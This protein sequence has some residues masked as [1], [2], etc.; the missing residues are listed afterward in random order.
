[1]NRTFILLLLLLGVI[2]LGAQTIKG[3]ITNE[4]LEPVPFANVLVQEL[5]T[6]TTSD[7]QGYYELNL[8]TEGNY[9]LIFSSLGYTSHK[10][11]VI[12][13]LEPYE[14]NISLTTSDVLLNEITVAA[15]RKDPAYAIIKKVVER[16]DRH[17]RAADSYRTDIYVK[18]VEE[19]ERNERN[20]KP[21]ITLD[22]SPEEENGM[23][24][25]FAEEEKARKELLGRLNL[26]EME[27]TLNFKQPRQYKEER[28]AYQKY[29]NTGG[30]F[31]PRFGE[32]D[33]N[34]Y[35]NMVLLT[36][37]SDAPVISPLS[38]TGVLAYKYKLE[39]TNLEG[40]Q[41]VYEIKVSPRKSGNSTC[42]GTIW[43]N[44]DTYTINRLDLTFSKYP[45]KFFDAFRLQQEYVEHID[46]LW[47]V[48]KQV[49]LY[50]AKQGKKATFRGNTTLSYSNYEHNYA[51]P[52]KFFG[53][54]VA[55]T[56]RE[57]YKRDSTYWEGSRTVALT[58]EEAKMINIR[59]SLKAI[60]SSKEYQ[61]SLQAKYNKI[62]LLE[63]AWE[64]VGFRNNAK[65][66]HL[67]VG[68]LGELINFS[69]VG[70]WRF[71]PYVGYNRRYENGKMVNFSGSMNYGLLN[72]DLLGNFNIWH[73]YNPFNLGEISVSGGRSFESIN[74]FDAY[75]NQLRPSNYI[76]LE[77]TR[78]RHSIEAFNGFFIWN[79]VDFS[80]RK[81]ITGLRTSS[82]LQD[83]VEDSEEPQEFEPYEALR[84]TTAITFTPGLKYMREPDRK[85]RLGSRW[86]TFQILYRK[87]WNGPLSSDIDFDYLEGSIKQ[88]LRLGIIGNSNYELKAGKFINTRDLRFIDLKRFRE[89]DPFLLSDPTQTF[90]VLD[91]S[92]TTSNLFFEFHHIHHFNGAL[93]NNVPLLKKTRIKTIA[94]AGFLWLPEDNFR[95]QEV[96][97]GIERV[98]KIGARRRLRIGTYAVLGDGTAGKADTS[99]KVSFDIIDLWKR[100]WSF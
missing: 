67:Y 76:K 46:S 40:S 73:R 36:G 98:F 14:L 41:I 69:V 89:S 88:E 27:V 45:L 26:V 68:S 25:P 91:T 21:A 59:D 74:Q 11:N 19:V 13:G 81:P 79:E 55:V 16:K 52:D 23:P 7:D 80:A 62:T 83:I 10:E 71:G 82:F 85:I 99:F 95:Y 75:L 39:S 57:A 66:S 35:R 49:F 31:I 6:G 2:P 44:E 4:F 97:V 8:Q 17:L 60:T 30:L 5:A 32:T 96:F 54:E 72:R 63:L 70:G 43:I 58:T 34:F 1:M 65:K 100:D 84:T 33:F 29:G 24:D 15:G 61:D 28:T 51:F 42:Q 78:F 53:N 77:A 9:R 87:G 92:L 86:P 94:G 64:G 90:N 20:R 48:S 47:T 12:I 18:A 50:V 22:A 37:I 3:Y 93:I 38:T 56:T